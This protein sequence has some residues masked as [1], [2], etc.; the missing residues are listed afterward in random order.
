VQRIALYRGLKRV[1]F[2]DRVDWKP[3][4]SMNIEQVF[5]LPQSHIEVRTGT[6]FGS[7]SAADMM[8]NA[9]PRNGDE[10]PKDTWKRWCQIQD[11]VFAGAGDWGF[12]LSADHQF[13]NVG[14]SALRAGM[15]RGTRFSPVNFERNGRS[16]Q[17]P[18]PP[19]GIYVF[20]YSFASGRSN[21]A[22]A[23]SWRAGMALNTPLIPPSSANELSQKPLPPTRSFCSLDGNNLIVTALKK[24][25][26]D[27]S[28]VLRAF[29][30]RGDRANSPVQFLGQNRKLS[31]V[32]LLEE[33][34]PGQEGDI[35]Q[36][37]PYEISTV[38]LHLPELTPGLGYKHSK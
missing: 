26:R 2:E 30:I 20:H 10:V 35:L 27:D 14:D 34:E 5:P 12:T 22:S 16:I 24:A 8:P 29:E 25:D 19:D 9:G 13:L 17:K 7:V 6:P 31:V 23:K 11:W 36:V 18:S 33:P 4:H 3:G 15:L 37:G 21:W 28:I 1:D 38:K 32:N